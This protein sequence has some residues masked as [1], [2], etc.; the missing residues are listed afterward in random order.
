MSYLT[1]WNYSEDGGGI[2]IR[3]TSKHPFF[4]H[5]QKWTKE[6]GDTPTVCQEDSK[7]VYL[8]H[9]CPPDHFA[10]SWKEWWSQERCHSYRTQDALPESGESFSS[11]SRSISPR[12]GF[13]KDRSHPVGS[14][15]LHINGDQW[16]CVED[17]SSSSEYEEE[18]VEDD[19]LGVGGEEWDV[20]GDESTSFLSFSPHA[21]PSHGAMLKLSSEVV[22]DISSFSTGGVFGTPPAVFQTLMEALEDGTRYL[23][24]RQPPG[25]PVSFL[26]EDEGNEKPSSLSTFFS[27]HFLFL[28]FNESNSTVVLLP[29]PIL[30]K[31]DEKGESQADGAAKVYAFYP[32]PLVE[33]PE[34]HMFLLL[35]PLAQ[36]VVPA[37]AAPSHSGVAMELLPGVFCRVPM[38]SGIFPSS[39]SSLEAK[40][41]LHSASNP[42]DR[43]LWS[44]FLNVD[45]LSRVFHVQPE[46]EYYLSSI[47]RHVVF[48]GVC[49]GLPWIQYRTSPSASTSCTPLG[50]SS[51]NT[52]V[53]EK[54]TDVTR[55]TLSSPAVP[56]ALCYHHKDL[57]QWY[58]LCEEKAL[59]LSPT[60]MKRPFTAEGDTPSSSSLGDANGVEETAPHRHI[61][62]TV[63]SSEVSSSRTPHADLPLDA[64]PM[65]PPTTSLT[66][67]H[68]SAPPSFSS[69][70]RRKGTSR[71][72]SLHAPCYHTAS[73]AHP[74]VTVTGPYG[75]P[76][77]C[78]KDARS[79]YGVHFPNRVRTRAGVSAATWV[80]LLGDTPASHRSPLGERSGSSSSPVLHED[81]AIR[82]GM[83]AT[84]MGLFHH[85]LVLLFD[86]HSKACILRSGISPQELNKAFSL[87]L[88]TTAVPSPAI[89][90][91]PHQAS[92]P[93]ATDGG[94]SEEKVAMNPA[95]LV[96]DIAESDPGKIEKTKEEGRTTTGTS[97]ESGI[98]VDAL[99]DEPEQREETS[100]PSLDRTTPPAVAFSM[101][102]DSHPSSSR[103]TSSTE[104]AVSLHHEVSDQERRASETSTHPGT[105]R[106]QSS[107]GVEVS[108]SGST[109]MFAAGGAATPLINFLKGF[110]TMKLESE[111]VEGVVD[112]EE[113]PSLQQ[114][115]QYYCRSLDRLLYAHQRYAYYTEHVESAVNFFSSHTPKE[116][117]AFLLDHET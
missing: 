73:T 77:H 113:K 76:I 88:T 110:A 97:S 92:L 42:E 50:C 107:C 95:G 69:D 43:V 65:P 109:T 36:K 62:A 46:R 47:H 1:S 70:P 35:P 115:T 103:E 111:H 112:T 57:M 105:S 78:D 26:T 117:Q 84:V 82:E 61:G 68:S 18:D 40:A 114:L 9:L 83:E 14:T 79:L 32:L 49:C 39:S 52:S 29:E 15:L 17:S 94:G 55:S 7:V 75:T 59:A 41:D 51:E 21:V 96:I 116:I 81:E 22:Y 2:E 53:A 86:G 13:S 91:L 87:V 6:D 100:I 60:R 31:T 93:A 106:V 4:A 11:D 23:Q 27:F 58:G 56:L 54:S 66:L 72:S 71:L 74:T 98:L 16:A 104:R 45:L 19:V 67:S 3:T 34:S 5:S 85:A 37:S 90:L 30:Y 44:P 12:S 63:P 89:P 102:E 33:I 24:Q 99:Q 38:T 8:R 48:L 101:K 64:T 80:R 108:S 28:G 20:K 25:F 10:A